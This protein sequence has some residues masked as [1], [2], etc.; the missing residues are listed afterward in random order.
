MSRKSKDKKV[1]RS[2]SLVGY[3]ACN[4]TNGK[5]KKR[6]VSYCNRNINTYR[7]NEMKFSGSVNDD[8]LQ[9]ERCRDLLCAILPRGLVRSGEV[10]IAGGFCTD[11]YRLRQGILVPQGTGYSDIDVFVIGDGGLDIQSF[12]Y[13]RHLSLR[14]AKMQDIR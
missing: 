4:N 5:K 10:G 13:A 6:V 3:G 8:R 9:V 1:K 14:K 11:L 2:R 7:S 12:F